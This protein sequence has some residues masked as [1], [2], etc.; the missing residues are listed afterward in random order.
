MNIE[1]HGSYVF[2]NNMHRTTRGSYVFNN[3]MYDKILGLENNGS[4]LSYGPSPSLTGRRAEL[5]F[6]AVILYVLHV[7]NLIDYVHFF[8]NIILTTDS[9]AM[10]T[11][12]DQ[13]RGAKIRFVGGKYIGKVGWLDTSREATAKS[14]PVIISAIKKK[15]GNIGDVTTMVRKTSVGLLD[16]PEA[17]SYVG[18][19]L[20]QHPKIT[21]LMDKLCAQLAMCDIDPQTA[22]LY[23]IF[24][25]KYLEAVERQTAKG[26]DAIWYQI[27]YGSEEA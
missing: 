3:N 8:L 13:R 25:E 17:E 22:L 15:D 4:P 20:Q 21:R 24:K 11:M 19:V 14:Y 18:A 10:T 16:E 12:I 6:H 9:V 26:S 5:Q 2:N 1:Q 7:G 27:D 23:K